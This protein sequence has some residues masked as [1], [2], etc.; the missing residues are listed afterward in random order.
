M[1][2]RRL[3]PNNLLRPT[4]HGSVLP[5]QRVPFLSRAITEDG[6]SVYSQLSNSLQDVFDW[7]SGQVTTPYFLSY[8][9]L[10]G[11]LCRSSEIS[12]NI[13]SIYRKS[14][15]TFSLSQGSLPHIHL[16]SLLLIWVPRLRGISTPKMM[17]YV[18]WSHLGN[19]AVVSCVSITLESF[20]SYNLEM[21]LLSC[22]T[23]SCI[24]I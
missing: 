4:Q 20:W 24:S 22:L 6:G 9:V 7:L 12:Q 8:L 18:L 5:R 15:T 11:C 17:A 21:W 14:I 16:P 10:R 2:P 1:H 23:R 3:H 19:G 13:S